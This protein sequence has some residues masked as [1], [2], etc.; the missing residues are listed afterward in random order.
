MH[1]FKVGQL[2]HIR[3]MYAE[4]MPT[5][6]VIEVVDTMICDSP[7]QYTLLIDGTKVQGGWHEW[8]LEVVK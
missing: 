1:K 7:H 5:A 8:D 6:V 4:H 2:V 3:D